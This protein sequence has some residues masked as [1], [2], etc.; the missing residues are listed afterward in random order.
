MIKENISN[1]DF[2]LPNQVF[3]T[4]LDLKDLTIANVI[5]MFIFEDRGKVGPG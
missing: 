1:L 2:N 5:I 4:P 3:L